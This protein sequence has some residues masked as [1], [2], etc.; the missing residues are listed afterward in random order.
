MTAVQCAGVR[1]AATGV[2]LALAAVAAAQET[3]ADVIAAAQAEKAT[4]L[5]PDD[6]GWLEDVVVMLRRAAIE[7][8]SG[9]FPVF[10]SILGESGATVG[11]GYRQFVGDR[12][13]VTLTAQYSS[14]RYS[15]A[16]ATL[17]SPG[18]RRDRVAFEVAARV[19]DAPQLGYYGLGSDSAAEGRGNVRV[20][21]T[22]LGGAA[23]LAFA[24]SLRGRLALAS[25]RFEATGGQGRAPS[26]DTAFPA[27][28][29]PGFGETRSYVQSAASVVHD[30]RPAAGY[31]RRGRALD[32]TYRRFD[33]PSLAGFARVDAD[34]VQ[35]VPLLRETWVLS[36]HARLETTAGG[37]GRVPFYLLPALGG[38][39]SLRGYP[40][41]R[42]RDRHAALAQ[43]EF[44]W[45]PN[46]LGLDMSIFADAGTV[47]GSRGGLSKARWHRDVGLGLRLHTFTLTPLRLDVARGA[48]GLRVVFSGN[49]VF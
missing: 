7:S 12:A 14:R 8:P 31:A 21:Q 40:I 44:R 6:P 42:F 18:H 26:A 5:R 22:A 38:G 9:P 35:H 15:A 48:E 29:R 25:E 43:G 13:H 20:R 19:L 37:A 28:E 11:A 34:V 45:I 3:R 1:L 46:R 36:G 41:F 4:M 49:A 17:T 24:P 27:S 32:V 30:T 2:A 39:D 16:A 47:A 23:T 33:R 10:G